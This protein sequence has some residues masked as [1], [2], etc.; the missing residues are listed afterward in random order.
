MWNA[1]GRVLANNEYS[2]NNCYFPPHLL[3]CAVVI[4][5]EECLSA[6][7]YRSLDIFFVQFNAWNRP[8]V[9]KHSMISEVLLGV[10]NTFSHAAN[11]SCSTGKKCHTCFSL[12]KNRKETHG[13]F[14]GW[15]SALG[16][17]RDPRV[18]GLSPPSGSLWGAC[19]SHCLCLCLSLSVCLS[20]INK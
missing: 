1:F 9:R 8:K 7:P 16:S 5:L 20:W 17:R 12:W 2:V 10:I 6:D 18:P 3:S 19:F 13:W 14:S 4:P 11:I 15:T